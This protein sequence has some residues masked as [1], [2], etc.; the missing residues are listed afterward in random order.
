MENIKEVFLTKTIPDFLRWEINMPYIK[1]LFDLE[2]IKSLESCLDKKSDNYS[3]GLSSIQ[4]LTQ[5]YE[6][7][8]NG[9][10]DIYIKIHDS[11]R[12]F[13]LLDEA[14]QSYFL[15]SGHGLINHY[16][17]I[18]SIWLRMG[19][20]DILDVEGFLERQINFIKNEPVLNDHKEIARLSNN[21]ILSY[22]VNENED[23]F[24]TNKNII[25]SIRRIPYSFLKPD[26]D[27][28]FPAIHFAISDLNDKKVCY[29]YG[30]QSLNVRV[31]D[32]I[33]KDIQFIRKGLRNKNVSAD[34]IIGMSLFLDYLYELGI[35]EVEIPTLQVFNYIYHEYLSNTIFDSYSSYSESDIEEIEDMLKCGVLTD[36]VTDYLHT[37]S[38]VSRFVDKQDSISYSKS[39]RFVNL[40]LELLEKNPNIELICEPFVQ[41]ENMKIRINGKCNIL[42]DYK[43]KKRTL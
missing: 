25:F 17:F 43:T 35:N 30:M 26:I 13:K 2:T 15:K 20:S 39:E 6:D 4:Y 1:F 9:K 10:D 38:M 42:K 23:W 40:F 22:R 14:V 3:K 28:D 7:S 32:E 18:R 33:K 21:E 24:E 27:Y 19:V 36:K 11:E 8:K 34:F 5:I 37:Y 16:N 29:I 31:A 41:G 12:F